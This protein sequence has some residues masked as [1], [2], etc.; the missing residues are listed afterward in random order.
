M[1]DAICG[2]APERLKEAFFSRG[3]ILHETGPCNCLQEPLR[4]H[5]DL[6]ALRWNEYLFVT[7]ETIDP[8]SRVLNGIYG[9]NS[10]FEIIETEEHLTGKYPGDVILNVKIAGNT[11]IGNLKTMSVT[12]REFFEKKDFRF[13]DVSQGYTGCSVLKVSDDLLITDDESIFRAVNPY[14]ETVKTEKGSILL[15]G[16]DYGFIGGASLALQDEI[17][18]F[19]DIEKSPL[20]AIVKGNGY[21]KEKRFTGLLNGENLLDIGGII[22]L[23][24][25]SPK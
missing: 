6:M 3:I 24:S 13:I 19:G 23:D 9:V 16:Y 7:P 14:I 20:K 11:V 21:C 4:G 10:P 25:E 2:T 17:F 5:I 12:V 15:P 1:I 18:L 8:V 22:P